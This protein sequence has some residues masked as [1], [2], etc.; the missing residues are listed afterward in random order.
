MVAPSGVAARTQPAQVTTVDGQTLVGELRDCRADFGVVLRTSEGEQRLAWDDV[1]SVD[2]QPA[3]RVAA[4]QAPVQLALIDDGVVFG[5]LRSAGP[6]RVAVTTPAGISLDLPFFLVRVVQ[7]HAAGGPLVQAQIDRALAD[8]AARRD[9]L[10]VTRAEKVTALPVAIERIGPDEVHFSFGDRHRT[11]DWAGVA[12]VIFAPVVLD[13]PRSPV[14]VTLSDRTTLSGTLVSAPE[15][16][17]WLELAEG[18]VAD[19]PIDLIVRLQQLSRRVVFVSDLEPLES[20]SRSLFGTT[21]PIQHDRSVTGEPISIVGQTSRKGLGVHAPCR[22]VY[23]L[24]GEFAVFLASVGIDDGAEG[25]GNAVFRVY[26]DDKEVYDSGPV[27]GGEPARAVS[28]KVEG[29]RRLTLV[30]EMGEDLDVADHADWANA[31]LVRPETP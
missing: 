19:L 20:E 6:G 13:R 14:R 7:R 29:V 25:K 23:A 11:A 18:V 5:E 8:E 28:V 1:L 10:L 24:D 31:R 9:T 27:R 17:L 22:L 4:D 21:W 3:D 12:A 2:V 16:R 26:A 30:V 15:G